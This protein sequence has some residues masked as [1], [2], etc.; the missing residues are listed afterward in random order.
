MILDDRSVSDEERIRR[1]IMASRDAR[2]EA[3]QHLPFEA[4][5]K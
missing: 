1:V 4:A 5:K 3:A 2:L